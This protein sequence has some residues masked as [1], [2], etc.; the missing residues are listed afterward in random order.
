M[1]IIDEGVVDG[2]YYHPY[3]D[4]GAKKGVTTLVEEGVLTGFLTDRRSA[5][6]LGLV[7]TGNGRV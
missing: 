3:D 2:G 6:K 4:E 7:P 1:T 5:K